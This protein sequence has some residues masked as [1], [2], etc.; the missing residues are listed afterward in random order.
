MFY[1]DLKA[2]GGKNTPR[3]VQGPKIGAEA[4]ERGGVWGG[5]NEPLPHQ[6][7]SLGEQF[8]LPSWVGSV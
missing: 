5:G 4:R 3:E 7:R 1:P 6:L 8:V 2:L